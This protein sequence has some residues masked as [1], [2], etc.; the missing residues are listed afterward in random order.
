MRAAGSIAAQTHQLLSKHIAPGVTPLELD[1]LAENFIRSQ[2]A[3]PAFL[4]YRNFPNTLCVSINEEAVHCIPSARK[5]QDGDLVKIDLGVIFSHYYSDTAKTYIVGTVEPKIKEFV[6]G[7]YD[8]MMA[9]INAARVGNYV[10]DIGAAI[11]EHVTKLGYS[12][13][14]QYIGHGI[15]N[16]LHEPPQVLNNKTK[17]PGVKLTEGMVLCIEPVLSFK[18]TQA[19]TQPNG[20]DVITNPPTP[21]THWEHSV[22]ITANG[23][24]ILTL[25]DDENVGKGRSAK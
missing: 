22:A 14:K 9:G 10:G 12:I 21:V 23:P 25:R 20:W 7:S 3:L 8:A 18:P 13:I 6:D 5:I 15:G 24:E 19:S 11:E 2:G 1:Q 4:G 17:D 16:Q